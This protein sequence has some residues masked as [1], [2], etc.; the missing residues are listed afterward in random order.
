MANFGAGLLSQGSPADGNQTEP[1][2]VQ[3]LERCHYNKLPG[4]PV[5]RYRQTYGQTDGHH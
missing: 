3:V 1:V 4:Y 5:F 2:C